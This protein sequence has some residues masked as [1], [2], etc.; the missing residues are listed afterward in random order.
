MSTI[1]HPIVKS[2]LA[3]DP[4]YLERAK[5]F[6]FK[7][8][9]FV[10]YLDDVLENNKH[11]KFLNF[12]G[13]EPF[14]DKFLLEKLRRLPATTKNKLSLMFVTN[15]SKD[16][17]EIIHSLGD[18][19]Y[20]QCSVSLEGIKEVQEWARYGSDW[21]QVEKNV[22]KGV[23]N[24]K[25][26]MSV[27]YTFQTATVLGFKDLAKWCQSNNIKLGT[28]IVYNPECLS[29]KT[30]PDNIKKE[31]LVDIVNNRGIIN[32]IETRYEDLLV[33]VNDLKYDASLRDDFFEYIEWYES[34]KNI[35]KLKNIFPQL[36]RLDNE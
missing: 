29:V 34:N 27:L 15:A 22:L 3:K 20:V 5:S 21:N 14:L 10:N 24:P 28:N 17:S 9:I 7:N 2:K 33:K 26:D 13:G 25:I 8:K 35:G 31:L 4:N 16:F 18:F 30:L 11:I 19:K 6:S 23:N 12:L 32:N 36:Y 1:D